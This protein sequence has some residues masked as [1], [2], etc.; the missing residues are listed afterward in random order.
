MANR[1]TEIYCEKCKQFKLITKYCI[2]NKSSTGY[3]RLKY[4]SD[5]INKH[6]HDNIRIPVDLS[7]YEYMCN[8][9]KCVEPAENF[10]LKL[11]LKR[12][13]LKCLRDKR[14]KSAISK[15]VNK[16]K[17]KNNEK[18]NKLKIEISNK[19]TEIHHQLLNEYNINILDQ[20]MLPTIS[21]FSY[22][23]IQ[24]NVT[25]YINKDPGYIKFR[26]K[27]IDVEIMKPINSLMTKFVKTTCKITD[28]YD[29]TN[30]KLIKLIRYNGLFNLLK[31]NEESDL[32][33]NNTA[34]SSS[35]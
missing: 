20:I 29:C 8:E 21:D 19:L 33:L 17:N 5:C 4:C 35:I 18:I 14:I 15:N 3:T 9:C 24:I 28:I 30:E 12:Y 10:A 31:I 23:G 1:S 25:H 11:G 6:A 7:D 27:L 22:N 34:G 13:C 2:N 32:L 26:C 16:N